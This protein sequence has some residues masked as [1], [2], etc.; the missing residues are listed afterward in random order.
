LLFDPRDRNANI[1]N[2]QT[3]KGKEVDPHFLLTLINTNTTHD[4]GL[5]ADQAARGE[6]RFTPDVSIAEGQ[7]RTTFHFAK[8]QTVN[9]T[10]DLTRGSLPTRIDLLYAKG[11]EGASYTV[12]PQIRACSKSRWFPERIVTFLKQ[13]PTQSPCLV[14]DFR[15]TE[16]DVDRRPSK[17]AFTIELPAGTTVNQFDDSRKYFKTRQPERVGPE[18]LSRIEQLTEKVPQEPQTDTTIVVPRQYTWI[19]YAVGGI[20]LLAGAY[21]GRRH[22][23][24]R[25][26]NAPA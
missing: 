17:E 6:I 23:L 8:D 10:V 3:Q 15:V 21:F 12:V 14:N 26:Q 20:I 5:L 22:V 18:H 16:L 7:F 11:A 24:S 25:G 1:Y 9:Y 13:T 2:Q 19:W 4:F